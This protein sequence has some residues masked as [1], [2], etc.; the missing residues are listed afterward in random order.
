MQIKHWL[1]AVRPKTLGISVVPVLVGTA[2]AWAE[3]N[4]VIWLPALAALIAAILIQIGTNLYNDAADFERGADT[5][6]RLGP[7]RA[8]AQGWFSAAQVKRAALIS[9]GSAFLIGIYLA[10]VGGWPIILIGLLSL[11]AGYAYTGGPRPIAYS[12]SGEVFV[13]IFFGLMAVSGSYYLQTNSLTA[14]TLICAGAIGLLAA[15]VLL[16]NNYRDLETDERAAK[17]TLTHYLGRERARQLYILLML[18]PFALPVAFNHR[19]D[20]S[21]LVVLCLPFALWLLHRFST[22]PP[23]RGFND[24]LANTAK[25]QLVYGALLSLGL[26]L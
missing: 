11:L 25:L 9:F 3:L 16:V 23:G 7:K 24:I 4:S 18:L 15:A 14:E 26:I 10:W 17:L 22:E 5:P 6:D 20:G 19:Y 13:F 1:L 21:W 2:L 12:A 8:T